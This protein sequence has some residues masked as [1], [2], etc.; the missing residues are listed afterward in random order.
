M[1][2]SG[3]DGRELI[4]H[5]HDIRTRDLVLPDSCATALSDLRVL[6]AT[7]SDEATQVAGFNA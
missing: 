1:L 6:I 4:A 5:R 7:Q 2:R 3:C